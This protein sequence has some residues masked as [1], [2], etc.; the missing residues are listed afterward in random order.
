MGGSYSLGI[1][2]PQPAWSSYQ[3]KPP[4]CGDMSP[5]SGSQDV[6][7]RLQEGVCTSHFSSG[8]EEG[9]LLVVRPVGAAGGLNRRVRIPQATGFT[10]PAVPTVAVLDQSWARLDLGSALP[11]TEKIYLPWEESQLLCLQ[12]CPLAISLPSRPSRVEDCPL[13]KENTCPKGS[14]E[15]PGLH[16]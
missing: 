9:L 15:T 4:Q 13:A 16:G 7:S 8:I 10:G 2:S 11:G 12:E 1:S 6:E 14:G 5:E 3:G